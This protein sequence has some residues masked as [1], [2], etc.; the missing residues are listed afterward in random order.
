MDNLMNINDCKIAQ[1]SK[2]NFGDENGIFRYIRS[3]ET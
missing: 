1:L 3:L 2:L